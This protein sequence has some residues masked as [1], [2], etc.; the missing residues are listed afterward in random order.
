MG[1][2]FRVENPMRFPHEPRPFMPVPVYGPPGLGPSPF[3]YPGPNFN[4]AGPVGDGGR[5]LNY[6]MFSS[7]VVYFILGLLDCPGYHCSGPGC[8]IASHR[9]SSEHRPVNPTSRRRRR[10]LPRSPYHNGGFPRDEE[11]T[12]LIG[13]LRHRLGDLHSVVTQLANV[14]NR[15]N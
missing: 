6:C 10:G 9:S 14:H 8:P 3:A 12:R 15:P 5:P 13:Q 11:T 7:S 2:A 4:G 1:E